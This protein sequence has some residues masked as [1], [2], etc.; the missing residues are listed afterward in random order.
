MTSS[1]TLMCLCDFFTNHRA[2]SL[3][4]SNYHDEMMSYTPNELSNLLESEGVKLS[5]CVTYVPS[6][7]TGKQNYLYSLCLWDNNEHWDSLQYAFH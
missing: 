2:W 1:K 4:F 7:K 6:P 5:S 3:T